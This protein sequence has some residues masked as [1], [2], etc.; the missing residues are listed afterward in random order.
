MRPLAVAAAL[1]AFAL[2]LAA[3]A[4]AADGPPPAPPRQLSKADAE[5]AKEL[6]A[7]S[8][9]LSRAGKFAEAQGP[10]REILDLYTRVLGEDHSETGDARRELETLKKLGALPEADRAEY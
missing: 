6:H 10:V 9:E 5:R 1:A 7:R 8:V 2:A 3:V 4:P